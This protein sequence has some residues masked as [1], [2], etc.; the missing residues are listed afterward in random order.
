MK[1][2]MFLHLVERERERQV[3][4]WGEQNHDIFRWLA[5]LGEECGEADK[6][7]LEREYESL[8]VWTDVEKELIEA[9]A[10][11]LAILD[12]ADRNGWI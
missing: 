10:V 8:V 7:A 2:Q 1:P 11:I 5:I 9:A 6:V 12:Y 3:K 4:K